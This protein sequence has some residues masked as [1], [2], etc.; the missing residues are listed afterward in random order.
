MA[1]RF[2]YVLRLRLCVSCRT[3]FG[4]G[5]VDDRTT[6]GEGVYILKTLPAR[7]RTLATGKKSVTV[8]S[9]VFLQVCIV[10]IK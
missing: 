9:I 10:Y 4:L 2:G 8:L 1:S 3:A 5:L 6:P 7:K